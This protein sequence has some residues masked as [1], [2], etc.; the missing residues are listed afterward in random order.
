MKVFATASAV[1]ACASCAEAFVTPTVFTGAAVR[2][3]AASTSSVTMMAEM[4]KSVP[5]LTAPKGLDGYVG[6]E[7][8]FDPFGFAELI[9]IKWLREAEIK[10][11]RVAML[12]TV[13]WIV[14]EVVHIPGAAY[15]SENP[16]DA[17]AAVGPSPMLQIFLFCGWL[18]YC[19][20]KGKMT[21]EDMFDDPERKP[22]EFGFDPLNVA[23]NPEKMAKYQLQEIKHGRLAMSAIGGLVHQSLLTGHGVPFH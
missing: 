6:A 12:A 19:Y 16:V 2:A 17:M 21:M 18:E 4:S 14:S 7:T 8:E 20:N 15:M 1:T 23:K 5:F 9:D 3:P 22:G 13:G 11:G 10:H